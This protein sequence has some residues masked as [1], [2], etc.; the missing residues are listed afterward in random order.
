[1][2]DLY[3]VH[4]NILEL[5]QKNKTIPDFLNTLT[6]YHLKLLDLKEAIGQGNFQAE[7]WNNPHCNLYL[8]Y[9]INEK[10]IPFW[11][12]ITAYVYLIMKMQY[13][14]TQNLRAEDYDVKCNYQ[15]DIVPLVEAGKITQQGYEYLLGVT[16]ALKNLNADMN[17]EHLVNY[18]LELP[19]IE[20]CLIKTEFN[21]HLV[22]NET[23]RDANRLVGILINNLPLIQKISVSRYEDPTT[24][25]LVPSSSLIHY[26]L[27]ALNKQPMWM[28]PVLGNPGL[29][30]LYHWH[31]QDFHPVSLYATQIVS[32]PKN[33]DGFR[34]GPFPMWLHDIGHTF[35]ASMLS[36]AQRDYIFTTYVPA[37]RC[38]KDM[39]AAHDDKLSLE[40]L[41]ETEKKAYDFDLTAII[42][43][44][45]VET[46]FA[47]YLAHTIGKNPIYP[48][49]VYTGIYEYEAIGRAVGDRLYFLLHYCLYNAKLP[50]A[51]REVYKLLVSFITIGKHYRNQRVVIALQILAKNATVNPKVL[52]ADAPPLLKVN[53]LEWQRLLHAKQNSEELWME[54]TDDLDLAYDL[55]NM[56][57][58]GLI[59]FHPYLPMTATK[60]LAL[61]DYLEKQP[62]AAPIS[63]KISQDRHSNVSIV[64]KF[65]PQ[66]F[67]IHEND[68]SACMPATETRC[69]KYN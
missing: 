28:R 27:Q 45:N 13:T 53:S 4:N 16:R 8:I 61:L 47:I 44:A 38:L 66:F 48:N 51:Y 57:E 10:M 26:F 20:Q 58:Q 31:S 43:Y 22:S 7:I 19:R 64:T 34:C 36:K 12:G 3:P 59:F 50:E 11:Q 1:M 60:R 15:V 55:L 35:W 2:D 41:K 18:V 65:R 6:P 52:F 54:A 25:Y 14:T 40:F 62:A 17:F 68:S 29:V 56:I 9:L 5:V 33:A 37:L 32:N 49:C 23:E 30:T 39:A 69:Y 63:A 24:N 42:D 46:R 67:N 21:H